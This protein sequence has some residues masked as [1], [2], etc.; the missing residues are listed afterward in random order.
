[1]LQVWTD[2]I[3]V[4]AVNRK[5]WQPT[6]YTWI[7]N[8]HFVGGTK[9]ENPTFSA[10]VPTLFDHAK[11]PVKRKAERQLA[12]YE[13]ASV[14]KRRCLQAQCEEAASSLLAHSTALKENS[15]SSISEHELSSTSPPE[16]HTSYT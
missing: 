13:R 6:E 10:Y 15:E 14:C 2:G 11:T 4:A 8:C 16:T 1:M 9:S 12:R 7:C 3:V 5:N